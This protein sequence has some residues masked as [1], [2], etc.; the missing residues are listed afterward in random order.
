VETTISPK[1]GVSLKPS[2]D[3]T[4]LDLAIHANSNS[5]PVRNLFRLRCLR[6]TSPDTFRVS[7]RPLAL[8]RSAN[9]KS[10]AHRTG[11]F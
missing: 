10:A 9:G 7:H 5:L 8:R 3:R 1:N 6:L 4:A 2:Y 11:D